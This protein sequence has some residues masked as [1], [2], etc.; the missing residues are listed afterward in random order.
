MVGSYTDAMSTSKWSGAPGRLEVW[1]TT[2]TD[3]VTGTG[4]WLHTELVAPSD[5]AAAFVHGWAAVFALDAAPVWERF[6]PTPVGGVVNELVGATDTMSWDLRLVE[7]GGHVLY[8]FPRYAWERGILP[9]AQM[10]PAPAATYDGTVKVGDRVFALAGARGAS[11]RI[12]GHGSARR[13]GWLH[14]DLGGGDVLEVVSA[15][16]MRP[17]LRALPP[18][19]FLQLRV[20]GRDL[21]RDPLLGAPLLR[22]RLG[23]PEWRVRGVIDPVGRRRIDVRVTQ[24]PLRTVAV[25]YT[26][27]D[28]ATATCHNSEVASVEVRLEKLGRTGWRLER[29][30]LL[31]RCAHAEIGV[32]S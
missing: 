11:A 28:G 8:T 2:L 10:V 22:A 23:L 16:S 15:V 18:L 5:G 20:D 17:G 19:S 13:W 31:D 26:D 21:P 4:F 3:P 1:Y 12:Y 7:A 9:A 32:R 25:G 24:D 14:A 6:G 27:P 30:W 29:E